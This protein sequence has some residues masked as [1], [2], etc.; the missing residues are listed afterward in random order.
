MLAANPPYVVAGDPHL[1]RGDLRFEPHTALVAPEAG[2][3]DIQQIV[4]GAPEHL[5][6]GGWLLLEHGFEQ[7]AA[8]RALLQGAGFDKVETRA[9][10]A[11]MDRI[12][13]GQLC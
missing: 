8:V 9:D 2:L 5:L 1:S 4:S 6:A 7:G 12:T 13:G 10:I 11:G 3:A